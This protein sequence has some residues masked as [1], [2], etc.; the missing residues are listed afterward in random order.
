LAAIEYQ[1]GEPKKAQGHAQEV[2]Q[3]LSRECSSTSFPPGDCE[4]LYGRAGALQAIFYL[5][6][7]LQDLSLG[8][9]FC[10]AT[11]KH[12]LRQG[13]REA[14]QQQDAGGGSLPL[15]WRWHEKVYLGAAHGIVGILQT[16]LYLQTEE[17]QAIEREI[18]NIKRT[19]ESTI[20][21]LTRY[22]CLESGNM[23][24]SLLNTTDQL[25]HWCHGAPGLCLLL[26]QA[27]RVFSKKE[28]LDQA[29]EI[30]ENVIWPRGLLKKGLGLFHGISGNAFIFL[31]YSQSAE[32]GKV[33]HDRANRYAKFAIDHWEELEPVPD[34]PYSLFEGLG[35]FVCL[36]LECSAGSSSE[37]TRFPLYEY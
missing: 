12:I 18:P 15:L 27:S 2:V 20:D 1:L 11:A 21:A 4:V 26:I 33:W 24:S 35:G 5:R 8:Q 10:I 14:Q 13:L 17:W 37:R 28:Y 25:V 9:D 30:T 32:D 23:K 19:I 3:R 16:L 36:L 31:R 6:T 22:C 7:E 29:Q 34:R